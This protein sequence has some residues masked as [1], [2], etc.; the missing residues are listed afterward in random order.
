MK[1]FV[2]LVRDFQTLANV[3]KNS[4][5]VVAGVLDL[6]NTIT[7]SNIC[8]RIQINYVDCRTVVRNF[9]KN[10]RVKIHSETRT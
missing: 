2:T 7:F 1:P 5:S 10:Y 9:T 8:A 6:R 4:I 3:T